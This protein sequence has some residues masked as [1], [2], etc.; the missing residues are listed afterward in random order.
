MKKRSKQEP[1]IDPLRLIAAS[2]AVI[3]AMQETQNE[4]GQATHPL[5][6]MGTPA[7]P[8]CLADYT[9][10]EVE[11]ATDFLVRLGVLEPAAE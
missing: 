9:R 1:E 7:Q 8:V 2:E 11:Q 3:Q 6:L 10:S 4:E 5:S